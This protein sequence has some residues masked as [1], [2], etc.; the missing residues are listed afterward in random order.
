MKRF[1]YGFETTIR[2]GT[3]SRL[4]A[5]GFTFVLLKVCVF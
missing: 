5:D 3:H 1:R 2:N 4:H